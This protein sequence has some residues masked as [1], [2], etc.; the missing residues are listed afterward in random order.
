MNQGSCTHS[1]MERCV[2]GTWIVNEVRKAVE[3]CYN[4]VTF[5]F[6]EYSVTFF[7][8]GTNSGGLFAE[9]FDMFPKLKH[10]SSGY[11]YWVHTEEDKDRYIEDSRRAEGIAL[12]KA[13]VSKN[14]G[15]ELWQS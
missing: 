15:N 7:D 1:D 13:S 14:L 3:M 5:E 2:V 10:E 11:P 8:K 9:Y 12:Y 4:L 6:W